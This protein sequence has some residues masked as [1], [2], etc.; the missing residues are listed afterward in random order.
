MVVVKSQVP[1][2]NPNA[3]MAT[4]SAAADKVE[5]ALS[6]VRR[7]AV[8]VL[9]R[10]ATASNL[11]ERSVERSFALARRVKRLLSCGSFRQR[12]ETELQGNE[13]AEAWGAKHSLQ[14]LAEAPKTLYSAVLNNIRWWLIQFS[15]SQ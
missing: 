6:D 4:T 15:T 2:S 3:V 5:R 11:D 14:Q 12:L 13:S 10:V 7:F 9:P 8:D 1:R